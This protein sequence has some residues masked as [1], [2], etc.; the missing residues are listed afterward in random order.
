MA[1]HLRHRLARA[2]HVVRPDSILTL[3]RFIEP[4]VRD[5]PQASRAELD[6]RT[7]R[8]LE[9]NPPE[10]FA[11]LRRSRGLRRSVVG[12][13]EEASTAGA[14]PDLIGEVADTP[15]AQA[16]HAVYRQIAASTRLRAGRLAAAV[17][18]IRTTSLP[19]R[20][21]FLDGFYSLT[22]AEIA[23]VRTLP[24]VTLRLPDWEGAR[25]TA[26]ALE[27]AGF[28]RRVV[29]E[30]RT[31]PE[32]AVLRAQT[33]AQEAEEIARRIVALVDGGRPFREIGVMMRGEHPYAPLFQTTFERF[34]IPA[35]FYFQQTLD[36]Q[37]VVRFY[38]ALL[39][40][41]EQGWDY[42]A[43]LRACVQR[44][45]GFGATAAGDQ[46]HFELKG[47]LPGVG[48]PPALEA[49][50]ELGPWR[51]ARHSPRQWAA[52]LKRL[53]PLV[54]MP[55][56]TD[57]V[58][59]ERAFEWR[60]LAA[61]LEHWETALEE[62]AALLDP[63]ALSLAQFR[64]HLNEVLN[65][66]P[67]DRPEQRRNVVHVMDVYEARQWRLPVMFLCGLV[68]RVFPQ[69]HSE[70]PLLND[71]QRMHLRA[72]GA[73]LR[74]SEERQ[75]E[76]EF[77]FEIAVTRAGERLYLS[78]P[79]ASSK[80][81]ETLPS[82]LVTRF[83][84]QHGPRSEEP[85]AVRPA[86]AFEKAA[87]PAPLIADPTLLE[88][89]RRNPGTLSPTGIETYLQCPFQFFGRYHLKLTEPPKAPADRLDFLLQG[90]ILHR[91]LAESHGAPLLVD[92]IFSRLFT[93]TC[94][95]NA[96]P[97][98]A[99]TEKIR[100]ELIA[101]LT[102][103]LESEPLTGGTVVA[104]E[105]PFEIALKPGL[106]LRGKIDR[107]VEVP[108]RGLVVIDFKYSTRE[109]IRERVRFHERGQL[110]QGGLYLWAAER[111]FRQPAAGM[112]YCGLRGDVAW[113]GWH[114]PIFSWDEIGDTLDREGLTRMITA[115]VDST[116]SVADRIASGEIAPAP[117]DWN[118]C[119]WCEFRDTCRVKE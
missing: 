41:V 40:A 84:R 26:D 20:E 10:A 54:S 49:W 56:V 102:R 30:D 44:R 24:G 12:L 88:W 32:A 42:E 91:T 108:K 57:G 38:T 118:K 4:F 47:K 53:R 113:A 90:D 15:A 72:R 85:A 104:V 61:S 36:T 31:P 76:E 99:R 71:A 94:D 13:M 52:E 3:S 66:T 16:F 79:R 112:L 21:Y 80:G 19:F 33:Q 103:F 106:K 14:T 109:R 2:G 77:L 83:E 119:A 7:A 65:G 67:F 37:P 78:Y 97:P 62:T 98:S 45:S 96:V 9:E 18:R 63:A 51:Q 117:A 92:E 29:R 23:I 22:P 75:R 60:A 43:V 59:H 82:F 48:L 46:L 69:Y 100:L 5:V 111:M 107:V 68:E 35:S 95:K 25:E 93:E 89:V 74:T 86:P 17:E 34:G 116:Q 8:L 58:S 105:R 114:L 87:P 11:G 81:E 110:V 70:H 101:N 55:A 6:R 27:E 64:E 115:A 73:V 39:D 28:Q 1:E 50:R